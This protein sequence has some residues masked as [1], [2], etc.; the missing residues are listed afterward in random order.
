[1]N[2]WIVPY[3]NIVAIA[4]EREEKVEIIEKPSCFGGAL[5][6]NHHYLLTS[7]LILESRFFGDT[8]RYLVRCGSSKLNLTPVWASAGIED[9]KVENRMICITYAGLGG[10][11]IGIE[12]RAGAEDVLKYE[13]FNG[14]EKRGRI[15]LPRRKRVLIG[16]D[17]T[18][19]QDEGATWSL[20]HNIASELDTQ[21]SRYTSHSIVQLFPVPYKTQNCVSVVVEFGCIDENMLLKDFSKILDERRVSEET[22]MVS[23]A[24]FSAH[25]LKKFSERCR[26]K[27]VSRK[28]AIQ[29]ISSAGAEIHLDGRGVI[30]AVAAIP[31]FA[32]SEGVVIK[33]HHI[34]HETK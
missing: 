12:C 1:M 29:E 4:D 28:E 24:G 5:W 3:K 8:T 32:S 25:Q 34:S 31:Y 14:K 18:D 7:P 27:E 26:R 15:Y 19:T 20:V 9:V 30:G 2:K 17:D 13:L 23:F 16:V 6:A 21:N 11:G 22:G 33:H 10:A